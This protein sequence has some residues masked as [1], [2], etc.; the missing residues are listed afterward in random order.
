MRLGTAGLQ[1]LLTSADNELGVWSR[2]T[3]GLR[4]YAM[5]M[6]CYYLSILT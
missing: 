1:A 6:N 3:M 2:S 4:S 5:A